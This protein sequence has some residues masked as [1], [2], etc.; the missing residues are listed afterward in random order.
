MYICSNFPDTY[1][2][3]GRDAP[4]GMPYRWPYAVK[5]ACTVKGSG[6]PLTY[7]KKNIDK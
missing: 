5:V 2:K 6:P 7:L 3:Q 1:E 4:Q